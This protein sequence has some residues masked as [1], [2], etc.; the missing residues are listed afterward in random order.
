M[1]PWDKMTLLMD[2]PGFHR[3]ADQELLAVKE[4]HLKLEQCE[5]GQGLPSQCERACAA[6][7]AEL[8]RPLYPEMMQPS[9]EDEARATDP[10]RSY[11]E[12]RGLMQLHGSQRTFFATLTYM[13]RA[14]AHLDLT[15]TYFVTPTKFEAAVSTIARGRVL[16][17]RYENYW[18]VRF[19]LK[20]RLKING[21][22]FV[23][24]DQRSS[25]S[26]LIKAEQEEPLVVHS[27]RSPSSSSTV[28]G[29]EPPKTKLDICAITSI[30]LPGLRV[31]CPAH[32]EIVAAAAETVAPTLQRLLHHLGLAELIPAFALVGLHAGTQF[33]EFCGLPEADKAD[34]FGDERVLKKC[35]FWS[36]VVK[37]E[38]TRDRADSWAPLFE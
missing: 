16:F 3:S 15:R 2:L 11:D 20:R 37:W 26:R 21:N 38:F 35:A 12:L 6:S 10:N 14:R 23:G 22:R 9:A 34:V 30:A 25:S 1:R 7:P 32:A 33:L 27:S 31:A 5:E 13:M 28:C 17:E 24:T 29:E 19:F 18:P 8:T 4:E 36:A